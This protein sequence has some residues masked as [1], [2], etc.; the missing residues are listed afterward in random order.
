[1]DVLEEDANDETFF[2]SFAKFEERCKEWDRARVI[3]KYALENLPK[4]EAQELYKTYISFEKQ[5]GDREGIE[6]VIVGKRRFQY[7]SEIASNPHNYDVWFDYIR[8]EESH[9]ELEKIR[10]THERAIANLC[11]YPTIARAVYHTP[12]V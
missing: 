3:Y 4:S 1:M 2:M 5:H 9:G 10:D 7:E 11:V 12:R 6:D 8:L